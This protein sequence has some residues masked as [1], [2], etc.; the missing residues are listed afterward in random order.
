M[1]CN[2]CKSEL[3]IKTVQYTKP[4]LAP[5]TPEGELRDKLQDLTGEVYLKIPNQYCAMCGEKINGKEPNFKD[6]FKN[7]TKLDPLPECCTD[8]QNKLVHCEECHESDCEK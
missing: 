6:F 5:L 4:L 7:V 1:A 2:Y 8:K 3:Y